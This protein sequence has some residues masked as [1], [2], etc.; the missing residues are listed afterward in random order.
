MSYLIGQ[1]RGPVTSEATASLPVSDDVGISRG[2]GHI[3]EGSGGGR[4]AW[5]V[6]VSY[7]IGRT[8]GSPAGVPREASR[9]SEARPSQTVG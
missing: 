9:Q 4:D 8:S 3:R 1:D 7:G 2:S 6:R 5:A